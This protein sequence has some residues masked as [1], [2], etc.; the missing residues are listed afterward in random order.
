MMKKTNVSTTFF[1]SHIRALR[2]A[3]PQ[4][5]LGQLQRV[6]DQG[7]DR[8]G[9]RPEQKRLVARQP[10]RPPRWC[11]CGSSVRVGP[12]TRRS[13]IGDAAAAASSEATVPRNLLER[14]VHDELYDGVG[15]ENQR[16]RRARPQP[17]EALVP[18]V[19]RQNGWKGGGGEGG[20]GRRRRYSM[21]CCGAGR[22]MVRHVWNVTT[23]VDTVEARRFEAL[24]LS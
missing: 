23:W 16:R 20:H 14:L 15:H 22:H 6:G 1:S 4:L 21:V 7:R 24:L 8:L 2:S 11:P 5:R 13:G 10:R 17:R 12:R 19:D 3:H 18:V 9:H